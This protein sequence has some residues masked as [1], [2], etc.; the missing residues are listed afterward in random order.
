M[1]PALTNCRVCSCSRRSLFA[2]FAHV[3]CLLIFS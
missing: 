1:F 3:F 2:A